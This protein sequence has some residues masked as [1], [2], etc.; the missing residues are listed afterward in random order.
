LVSKEALFGSVWKDSAVS[1]DALT[2]CIRELRKVFDDDSRQPRFIETRHRRGYRFVPSVLPAVASTVGQLSARERLPDVSGRPTIAVLPFENMEGDPAEE[3]F[4]DAITHDIITALSKY[5]SF[6][7]IARGSSFVFKGQRVDVRRIGLDLGARYIVEGSVHKIGGRVRVGAG[8]VETE[9][10]RYVWADQYDRAVDDIFE[11]QDEITATIASRIEPEVGSAERLRVGRK[12]R[13]ELHAWDLFHLGMKHFY[14]STASDNQE[15]QHLFRRAI[16]LDPTLAQ[17]Y[18]W[19]SYAEV[20]DMVYFDAEPDE[21]RLNHAVASS[22]KGVELD[23]Q[24]AMA[25]FT[26]GRALLAKRAYQDALAELQA[27]VELNP[28]LAIIY[29]GLGDSLAYE[30]RFDEAI[31]CFEKAIQLSPYDPQR[32]AYYS[33]RALAHLLSSEFES[34]LE[35][36]QNAVRI[37]NCHYWPFAHRVSAL[38]HLRRAA[39]VPAAVAELLRRKPEFSCELARERLFYVKNPEHLARYLEGL[40]SAGIRE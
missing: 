39:E 24:D 11:V 27:A 12:S 28:N 17:A 13:S 20:L 6:L 4:S 8:L 36:A 22:R 34:A 15:A 16:E 40:R 31:P 23:A 5:R 33:Y 35:W 18:A 1:D 7:V 37:P 14:K 26:C 19:L 29:C 32:W 9:S 38:G 30:G 10:G 2:T 3:Y 21:E 25:H